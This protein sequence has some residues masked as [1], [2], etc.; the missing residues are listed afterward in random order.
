M[1]TKVLLLSFFISAI[2]SSLRAQNENSSSQKE[3]T[4]NKSISITVIPKNNS[5]DPANMQGLIESALVDAGYNVIS[6]EVAHSI[7]S[8]TTKIYSDSLSV[9]INNEKS[10][11][12]K[13]N[14]VYVLSFDY[15]FNRSAALTFDGKFQPFNARIIDLTQGGKIIFS[16]SLHGTR[17]N[18]MNELMN[19]LEK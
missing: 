11:I 1:K 18:V 2:F 19:Y 9:N 16:K 4:I 17:K 14:S 5:S 3:N 10:R 8:N 6:D 13:V 15:F 7:A 12:L